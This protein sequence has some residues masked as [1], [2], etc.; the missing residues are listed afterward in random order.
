MR[1]IIVVHGYILRL[2][3]RYFWVVDLYC[4]LEWAL[5]GVISRSGRVI[6]RN[7]SS[8]HVLSTVLPSCIVL[9]RCLRVQ[10][11]SRHHRSFSA[12]LRDPAL[13][14]A[15]IAPPVTSTKEKPCARW[16]LGD[17]LIMICLY[18][19]TQFTRSPFSGCSAAILLFVVRVGIAFVGR[20]D[21]GKAKNEKAEG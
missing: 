19:S 12:V 4:V 13:L 1:S 11:I 7:S 6:D 15:I 14:S 20:L 18:R 3:C 21:H 8:R 9:S 10:I 17:S 2:H 5:P 16:L